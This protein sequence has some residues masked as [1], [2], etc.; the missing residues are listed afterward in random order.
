MSIILK[1]IIKNGWTNFKRQGGLTFATVSIMIMT[2]SLVTFLYFSQSIV[3][4]LILDLQDKVDISVFFKKDSLEENILGAKEEIRKVPE[5]KNVEYISR[6][7]ALDRFTQKHKDNPLLME[8][9]IEVGE[10]PLL[11]SLNIK[12]WQADQYEAL[13][14]FLDNAPFSD[15]VEKVDYYQNKAI[16][17]KIFDI[18]SNIRLA[19]IIFSLIFGII[20]IVVAFN[21]TRIAI[22]NSREEIS[23]MR[24]VGASN[25]FIRGPFLVQGIIV[26]IVATFITI[27]LFA[28]ANLLL[29]SKLEIIL[30]G[31]SLFSY[32][33]N[34]FWTLLFIQ[35]TAGIGL[36]M[37]SSIIAI[38]KY[39]KV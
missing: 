6:E 28:L 39:L 8:A 14:G 17:G 32:F 2:I 7:E 23:I 22:Y 38:R 15:L 30:P 26:G 13:A 18:S 33:L 12:A 1:R 10:N 3:Q 11:A 21:T 25:W 29:N 31:F 37:L 16:I 4:Y 36:S 35:L 20:A 5:V 24:L 19:G 9:L 34:H 27:I